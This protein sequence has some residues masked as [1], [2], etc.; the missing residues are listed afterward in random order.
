M[1]GKL[2]T[3]VDNLSF[4]R[5][6]PAGAGKTEK[7]IILECPKWDHPRGCGENATEYCLRND[8]D[9]SPPRVRGK[10]Y[11]T[12]QGLSGRRITPAGAGKTLSLCGK[13]SPEQDHP[14]GCGENSLV[15]IYKQGVVG[16]PPRVRGKP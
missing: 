14:R 10:L 9:G 11:E 3:I 13:T 4:N 5:I 6:T 16:S 15:C 8:Y 12:F 2:L 1:R 7:G